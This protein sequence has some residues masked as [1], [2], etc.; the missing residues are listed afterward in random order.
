MPEIIE[1]PKALYIGGTAE[2]DFAIAADEAEESS[3][4]E[5]G[6]AAI[7]EAPERSSS[8]SKRRREA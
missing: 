4:R 2:G 1:Y 3:L 8:P 7:G 6:Y 5:Q